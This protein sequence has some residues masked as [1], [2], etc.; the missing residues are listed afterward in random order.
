MYL[1]ILFGQKTAYEVFR[2]RY[3]LLAYYR[4]VSARYLIGAGYSTTVH[5]AGSA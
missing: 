5:I 2:K 3:G 4:G 1:L